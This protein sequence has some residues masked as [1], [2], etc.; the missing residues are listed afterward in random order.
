MLHACEKLKDHQAQILVNYN[1]GTTG[2]SSADIN[3]YYG[4]FGLFVNGSAIT[5]T[6]NS[7]GNFGWSSAVSGQNFRLGKLVSGN[8][9]NGDKLNEVAVWNSDETSNV[10]AIYNSGASHDL[11]AL[12]SSPTHWWRMGDGDTYPT[13]QDQ[14]GTADFVMYN[15]TAADIVSDTQ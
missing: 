6:S 2:V 15:M 14:I 4:R 10:S 7:H 3:T 13:I 1:G 11:S 5:T 9:M 8:T 12:A